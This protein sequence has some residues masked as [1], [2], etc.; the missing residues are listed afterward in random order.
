[1]LEFATVTLGNLA[2]IVT[3]M[4]SVAGATWWLSSK[5][6]CMEEVGRTIERNTQDILIEHENKDQQRHIEN[7]KRFEKISVALARIG[8]SNVTTD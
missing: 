2:S 5:F 1:M 7:L 6:R 8:A 3:I 4:V